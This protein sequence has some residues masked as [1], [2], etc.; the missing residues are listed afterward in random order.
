MVAN[1]DPDEPSIGGVEVLIIESTGLSRVVTTNSN[2]MLY[3]AVVPI[4][5]TVITINTSSLPV[6]GASQTSGTNP[7]VVVVTSNS[8][9]KKA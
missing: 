7:T 9:G 6:L 5:S 1:Q 4:G 3:T 8:P 2:G